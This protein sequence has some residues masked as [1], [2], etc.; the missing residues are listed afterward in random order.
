MTMQP[1]RILTLKGKCRSK[2]V[3]NVNGM[4]N[5]IFC[6]LKGIVI[7]HV[8]HKRAKLVILA[9]EVFVNNTDLTFLSFL[10]KINIEVS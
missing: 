8:F 10:Y 1:M 6:D 9:I 7:I 2:N 5:K 3:F 4:H